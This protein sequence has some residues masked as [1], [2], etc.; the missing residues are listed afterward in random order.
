MLQLA[1]VQVQQ[2]EVVQATSLG[3]RVAEFAVQRQ[4]TLECIDGS[5]RVVAGAQ[6]QADVVPGLGL[7]GAVAE[8]LADDQGAALAFQS[9]FRVAA[10][11]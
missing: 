1:A 5:C 9:A 3:G 7:A 11:T 2:A 6:A 4:R 8:F 10:L